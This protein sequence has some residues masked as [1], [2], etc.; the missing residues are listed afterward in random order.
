[1]TAEE[2]K[3]ELECDRMAEGGHQVGAIMA[4]FRNRVA[5]RLAKL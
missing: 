2:L 1:V 4:A 3:A 5:A